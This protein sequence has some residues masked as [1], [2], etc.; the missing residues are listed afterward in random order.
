MAL[1]LLPWDDVAAGGE[2]ML[3]LLRCGDGGNGDGDGLL[4]LLGGRCTC[5]RMLHSV[6]TRPDDLA[7]DGGGDAAQQRS[8]RARV[9]AHAAVP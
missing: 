1:L 3:V 8:A 7:R 2:S 6:C 4:P 9:A 5:G